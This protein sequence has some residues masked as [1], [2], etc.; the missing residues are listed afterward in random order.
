MVS[1]GEGESR[2]SYL[3]EKGITTYLIE[4]QEDSQA[5]SKHGFIRQ[6]R[7]ELDS[8][9]F[10]TCIVCFAFLWFCCSVLFGSGSLNVKS[11]T[12]FIYIYIDV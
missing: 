5:N 10:S 2:D 3:K 12:V 9:Y 11:E 8:M 1:D 4:P 7:G 6:G